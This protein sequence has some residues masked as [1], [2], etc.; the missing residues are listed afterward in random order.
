MQVLVLLVLVLLVLVLPGARARARVCA[1]PPSVPELEPPVTRHNQSARSI[2]RGQGVSL[3][4][5]PR[6]REIC[7]SAFRLC[8]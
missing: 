3:L 6:W 4:D 7:S 8:W 5:I 2:V 1:P